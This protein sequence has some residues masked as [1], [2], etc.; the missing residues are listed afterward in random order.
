PDEAGAA[1]DLHGAVRAAHRSL[2]AQQRGRRRALV[3]F[4]APAAATLE[5]VDLGRHLVSEA[6]QRL[7]RR[8]HV[9]DHLLDHLELANGPTELLTRAG[10][11]DRELEAA[12]G[13]PEADEGR[14]AAF[15]IEAAHRDRDAAVLLAD[16]IRRRHAAILEHELPGRAAPK[17]HLPELLRDRK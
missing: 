16:E 12:L 14:D 5:V 11:V 9:G 13:H 6:A 2:S 8:I 3:R 4:A 1:M 7:D 17:S 10:V 15:E